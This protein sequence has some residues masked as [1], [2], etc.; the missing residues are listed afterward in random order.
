MTTPI[1]NTTYNFYDV[2]STMYREDYE[3]MSKELANIFEMIDCYNR[4]VT[5]ISVKAHFHFIRISPPNLLF[6]VRSERSE[7]L[8]ERWPS[9]FDQ[10]GSFDFLSDSDNE[11][12]SPGLN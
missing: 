10:F 9:E 2:I 12:K 5:I 1:C 3:L 7:I 11:P 8:S 6:A 4:A